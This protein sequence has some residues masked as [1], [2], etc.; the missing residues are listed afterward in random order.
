MKKQIEFI[1]LL[2][3]ICPGFLFAQN[4]QITGKVTDVSGAPIVG[5]TIYQED[6]TS[7]GTTSATR[8][9]YH[10]SVPEKAALVFSYLGYQT[11]TIR[12]SG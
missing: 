7:N 8:G 2:L 9:I 1:F 3:T 11:Q 12:R 5:V 10:I 6:K 4:V